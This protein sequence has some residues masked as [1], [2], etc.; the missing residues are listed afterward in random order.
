M[1]PKWEIIKNFIIPNELTWA[2]YYII[3]YISYLHLDEFNISD[4]I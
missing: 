1:K 2:T 3:I 4:L